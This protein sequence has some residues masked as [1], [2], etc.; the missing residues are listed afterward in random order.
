MAHPTLTDAGGKP[1][2]ALPGASTF[3]SAISFGLIRGG[4]VD[5]TVLG[6][7]QVD[8]QGLL[9]N[10]MI[11][12]KMVPGMGGA[13]D[14]VTGAKRVVVAMQH[15]APGARAPAAARPDE[16]RTAAAVGHPARNR[17]A[18]RRRRGGGDPDHQRYDNP[19]QGKKRGEGRPRERQASPRTRR[20]QL[21]PPAPWRSSFTCMSRWRSACLGAG[22]ALIDGQV[23]P[24]GEQGDL[25]A[26]GV[27]PSFPV[28][29]RQRP[30][31]GEG[32]RATSGCCP[33]STARP[34]T[35]SRRPSMCRCSSRPGRAARVDA[36]EPPV[37]AGILV[38]GTEVLTG[39]RDR[40]QR[41]LDLRAAGRAR[42]RGRPLLS[43]GTGPT[44]SSPACASWPTRAWT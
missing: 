13:M 27:C 32:C 12:Q 2:T 40:P 10:W 14:L 20:R 34:P 35:A 8:Q 17:A 26:Q 41:P 44:T 29:L 19:K 21:V 22:R 38:T 7:L 18:A 39:A 37:R 33:R 6:G 5:M 9:A 1:V 42:R 15:S 43:S 36:A 28:R 24:A 31:D 4:H 16:P 11:P 23:L 25:R 3:D 30:A